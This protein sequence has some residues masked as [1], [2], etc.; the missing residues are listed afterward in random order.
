MCHIQAGASRHWGKNPRDHKAAVI[1]E[2]YWERYLLRHYEW[3]QQTLH[4]LG[5]VW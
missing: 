2:L 1:L 4:H 5:Q 3:H